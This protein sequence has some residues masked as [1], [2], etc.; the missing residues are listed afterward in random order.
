MRLVSPLILLACLAATPA[1][2]R[3]C[4]SAL[5]DNLVYSRDPL[6]LLGDHEALRRYTEDVEDHARRIYIDPKDDLRWTVSTTLRTR[7]MLGQRDCH[8][9]DRAGGVSGSFSDSGLIV[10]AE[11]APYHLKI[12]AFA[13]GRLDGGYLDQPIEG[14]ATRRKTAYL[15]QGLVGA[16][17][18][19]TRWLELSYAT[20]GSNIDV[21][22]EAE[23]GPGVSTS[24][25]PSASFY[26]LGVPA[27]GLRI[28]L[29]AEDEVIRLRELAVRDVEITERL[30]ASVVARR[31][32]IEDREAL[33]T[34]LMWK[35]DR[36]ERRHLALGAELALESSP[37]GVRSGRVILESLLWH[38]EARRGDRFPI[39]ARIEQL[40][41]LSVHRGAEL[42]RASDVSLAPGATWQSRL[43]LQTPYLYLFVLFRMGFNTPEMLD[44]QPHL[45]HHGL[46]DVG[47]H[48]SNHW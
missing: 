38:Y 48:L 30:A 17:I 16:A 42:R 33:S 20:T 41:E 29:T 7:L 25:L 24:A 27:L 47:I 1:A 31:F 26:S 5:Q 46:L 44:F 15:Q 12:K 35:V 2:A 28:W 3:T 18:Q 39:G 9:G 22:G 4:A 32:E 19:V 43:G 23:I 34:R 37:S 8:A 11:Y 14:E 10:G 45:A 40:A 6:I 36:H 13:T 21:S